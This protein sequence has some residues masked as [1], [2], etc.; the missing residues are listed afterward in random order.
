MNGTSAKIEIFKPFG[1]A[2]ELTKKI[3]FQPFDIKKWCVIGFAAFL[4]GN[5]GGPGFSWPGRLNSSQSHQPNYNPMAGVHLEWW[6]IVLIVALAVAI[7]AI[8][9]VLVWLSARGRFI[10]TDCIVRNRAAI[11]IPW[12][13]YRKE[14]NGYFLFTLAVGFGAALI[15]GLVALLIFVPVGLLGHAS[16]GGSTILL[17]VLFVI[18]FIIWV[19]FAFF[20]GLV[21]YFMVPIIYIRR[22]G[23]VEAFRVVTRLLLNNIGSFVLFCLFSLV[24]FLAVIVIGGI[25]S[26]LTCCIAALPYVGSVILLP[27]FV[28]LRAFGLLFLRQFGPEYDVWAGVVPPE[29]PA[30]PLPPPIPPPIQS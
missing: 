27:L 2:F 13:E 4:S 1:E 8:V 3:L 25:V 7:M 10:F 23:P 24:L 26:C 14:G 11:V 20:F 29:T 28:C 19:C 30:T 18:C 12:H 16:N 5:F 6:G 22:V 21:S 9:L 17:P 15:F